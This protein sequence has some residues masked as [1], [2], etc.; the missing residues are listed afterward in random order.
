MR[1]Y[2]AR[3]A[4]GR[5]LLGAFIEVEPEC[6]VFRDFLYTFGTEPNQYIVSWPAMCGYYSRD[7]NSYVLKRASLATDDE[8]TRGIYSS[9]L[10]LGDRA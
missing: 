4:S 5:P 9:G 8:D 6:V 7:D 3:Q 1:A 2:V 10:Y